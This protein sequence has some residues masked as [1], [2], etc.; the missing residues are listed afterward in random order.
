M[1]RGW[2][3]QEKNE[4]IKCVRVCFKNNLPIK[5]A[6]A[7]FAKT[8]NRKADSVRNYYY[9]FLSTADYLP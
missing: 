6:F 5:N 1:T 4:L 3:K 2:S 8:H 7:E 9:S